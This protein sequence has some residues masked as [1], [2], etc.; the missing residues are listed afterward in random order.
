MNQDSGVD[1]ES[2]KVDGGM[3]NN[4]LLMQFQADLLGVPVI[5]PAVAE[6]TALGA[7]YAAGLAD[8]LLE[9]DRGPAR[10]LGR[11]QALGAHRWTPRSATSTTSTGS[12]PSR[13]RST[14]SRP[15]R[16]RS[17]PG[18]RA[19]AP[20]SGSA[21]PRLGHTR[22]MTTLHADVLVIGGGATGAGVAW[23]CALRGYDT[24]LVDRRDLAEGTSG[25]FHG[26]LHSGGRYVVKDPDAA[27]ECVARERDRSGA[28]RP[29]RSRTRAGSSSPR[30]TTTRPTATSSWPAAARRT[31]RPRR[32]PSR[33]RSGASRG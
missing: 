17:R 14:G 31:C 33:R 32:S 26:L 6:T 2:L 10:E 22:V 13:G 27:V 28:S 15:T 9:R 11:G 20:G 16:S 1:L 29:T 7:A 4:D 12:A 21:A 23:D 5:R 3:V 30:R 8:G 24:I 25:R 18:R 19:G